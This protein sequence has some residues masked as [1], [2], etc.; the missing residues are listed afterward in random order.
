MLVY[1][2]AIAVA[3]PLGAS[4]ALA[5]AGPP[6]TNAISIRMCV[7]V[8]GG[9]LTKRGIVRIIRVDAPSLMKWK[10]RRAPRGCRKNEQRVDWTFG[11]SAGK[12]QGATGPMGPQ[13]PPGVQGAPGAKGSAGS[14]G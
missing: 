3:L 2:A 6:I 13:G 14:A 12:A 9:L 5:A 1:A 11:P 7:R 8:T 10:K 4:A